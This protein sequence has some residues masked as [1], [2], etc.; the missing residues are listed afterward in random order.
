MNNERCPALSRPLP[1][2]WAHR[3]TRR[4]ALLR[5]EVRAFPRERYASI[6]EVVENKLFYFE[7]KAST[8]VAL[9]EVFM[10]LA[11]PYWMSVAACNDRLPILDPDHYETYW[12]P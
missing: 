4:T 8:L 2:D 12:D 10:K 6:A 5:G 7:S 11:G 3:R 9:C 1:H